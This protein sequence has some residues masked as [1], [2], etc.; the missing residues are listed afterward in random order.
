MTGRVCGGNRRAR[1]PCWLHPRSVC[2]ELRGC[3]PRGFTDRSACVRGPEDRLSGPCRAVAG[4]RRARSHGSGSRDLVALVGVWMLREFV[5]KRVGWKERWSV[6]ILLLVLLVV[7]SVYDLVV[8]WYIDAEL[9]ALTTASAV[10]MVRFPRAWPVGVLPVSFVLMLGWFTSIMWNQARYD[11]DRA[12]RGIAASTNTIFGTPV[13][14]WRSDIGQ[15]E[16]KARVPAGLRRHA[17]VLV[18]GATDG[19]TSVY[20]SDATGFAG[21]LAWITTKLWFSCSRTRRGAGGCV[22]AGPWRRVRHGQTGPS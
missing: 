6:L 20:G 17:C 8:G 3:V 5:W 4:R 9:L 18:L 16:W 2:T 11:S 19:G 15:L 22:A 7:L 1:R 21:L 13:L 12:R 10:L 14:P